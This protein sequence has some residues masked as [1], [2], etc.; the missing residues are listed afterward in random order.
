MKT[1]LEHLNDKYAQI[2]ELLL[3]EKRNA[4]LTTR[5]PQLDARITNQLQ[6]YTDTKFSTILAY[7]GN[8]IMN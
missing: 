2:T 6:K 3:Q 8:K 4:S 5:K 7:Y 1:T